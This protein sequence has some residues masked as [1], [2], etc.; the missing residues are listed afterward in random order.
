MSDSQV[1][2]VNR[3]T[4]EEDGSETPFNW[5]EMSTQEQLEF[6][7]A[8]QLSKFD[9]VSFDDALKVATVAKPDVEIAAK[10]GLVNVPFV[11][12]QIKLNYGQYGP[13]VSLVAV[14]K[15]DE[16][17]IIND[18]GTGI[19][20]QC[21]ELV[22]NYGTDSPIVISGGLKESVY[23]IDKDSRQ[24]VS[25]NPGHPNTIPASTFYLNFQAV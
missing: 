23:Y 16:N 21:V 18:G 2:G 9:K 24:F 17:V 19:A 6:F 5:S 1:E 22:K 20:R 25:K 15:R 8:Q 4:G 14:T 11:I 12:R 3:P 10:K 13:F 7:E